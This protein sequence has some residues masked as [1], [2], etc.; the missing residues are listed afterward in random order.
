MK[1]T[2][3]M[4]TLI[5]GAG[6]LGGYFGGR[7]LA[8][9]AD[10]TFLVRTK[11]NEHLKTDGLVIRSPLGNL[12]IPSPPTV[13][14][15]DLAEPFDLVVVAC[16]AY[17]LEPTMD[18]FAAAVGPNTS[19]LPF[20]NGM[21]HVDRLTARFG[22]ERVLGGL[23]LISASLSNDGIVLHHNELHQLVF[24][25]LGGGTS[26]RVQAISKA[27]SG[28]KFELRASEHI[29]QEMWEKWVFIA[30]AAG[31]T[32]LMRAAVGDVTEADGG[33]TARA[34]LAECGSVAAAAGF[35]PRKEATER[36]QAVLM[37]K[38]SAMT[39]S[40]LRDIERGSRIEGDHII[41]DLFRRAP[42][43]RSQLQ[44]LRL[45]QTHLKAYE[46]RQRREAAPTAS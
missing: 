24:G 27:L 4:K 36:A 43:R 7:L 6:A 46:A 45:V 38:G 15:E 41:A 21:S 32:T 44:L 33:E 26:D 11:R 22:K 18:S 10:V 13:L 9:G 1:G 40:M 25:E 30:A 28:A 14:S 5:V 19:L 42:A 2:C 3:T 35:E 29:V 16:K 23:C 31:L 17:D 37:S 34:L 39:A 12:H 8:A 20:L